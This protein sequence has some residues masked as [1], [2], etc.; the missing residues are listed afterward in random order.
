MGSNT[1]YG[2][3]YF[4]QAWWIDFKCFKNIIS[5][6][7]ELMTFSGISSHYDKENKIKEVIFK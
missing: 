5:K 3:M 1:N 2:C 7:A 4:I 6:R